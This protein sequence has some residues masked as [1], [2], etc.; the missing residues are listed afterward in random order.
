MQIMQYDEVELLESEV[1]SNSRQLVDFFRSKL[2]PI[3]REKTSSLSVN[4]V[5]L[6]DYH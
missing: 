3:R 2:I 4:V 1:L 6:L 5:D